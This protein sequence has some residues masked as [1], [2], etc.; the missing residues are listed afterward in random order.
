[1]GLEID[2]P[3][4]FDAETSPHGAGIKPKTEPLP[5]SDPL[6]APDGSGFRTH[7]WT[8]C[9]LHFEGVL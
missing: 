2:D 5:C 4:G 1:M 3:I 8:P 9:T 7:T 6:D